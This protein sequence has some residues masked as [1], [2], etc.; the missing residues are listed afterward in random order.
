MR[1]RGRRTI[2][3]EELDIREDGTIWYEGKPKKLSNHGGGYLVTQCDSKVQY[4]HRLI[5]KRYIPNPENK[6][7]INH[8]DG[9]KKNNRVENLEWCT[10]TENNRH[11]HATGLKGMLQLKQR[12]LTMDE[13]REIRSKYIPRKYTMKRLSNEYGVSEITISFIIKNKR[14]KEK[15]EV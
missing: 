10:R 2:T 8:K 11:A 5:A 15:V 3:L 4:V 14:Y 6:K 1:R 12:K 7:E 13:A 9:N